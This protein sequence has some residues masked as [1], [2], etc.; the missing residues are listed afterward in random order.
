MTLV[1][2]SQ[3]QLS[4]VSD[5]TAAVLPGLCPVDYTPPTPVL[6]YHSLTHTVVA[7]SS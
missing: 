7:Q 5:H 3:S 6:Q 4:C 2:W 1:L